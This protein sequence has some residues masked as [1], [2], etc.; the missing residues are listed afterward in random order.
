MDTSTSRRWCI[1]IL[2]VTE[3]LCS[4]FGENFII[5]ALIV[6]QIKYKKETLRDRFSALSFAISAFS[7]VLSPFPPSRTKA[8]S[9]A[10]RLVRFSSLL[11]TFL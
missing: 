1:A 10:I 7:S 2:A 4:G 11:S 6:N 3:N 5:V 9:L 8:S